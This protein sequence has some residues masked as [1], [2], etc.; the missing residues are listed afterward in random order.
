MVM[1]A[2]INLPSMEGSQLGGLGGLEGYGGKA[3]L[4]L[5]DRDGGKM[6]L[7]HIPSA[8]GSHPQMRELLP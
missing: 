2:P 5:A 1:L 3:A 6:G 8:R 4:R 7:P